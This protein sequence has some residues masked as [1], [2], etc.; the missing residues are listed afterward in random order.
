MRGNFFYHNDP[1]QTKD[2]QHPEHPNWS[3]L[4]D[5]GHVDEDGFLDLAVGHAPVAPGVL[6]ERQ[7]E[8]FGGHRGVFGGIDVHRGVVGPILDPTKAAR[9]D[10]ALVRPPRLGHALLHGHHK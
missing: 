6:P 1:G 5:V 3:A 8:A 2:A 10:R 7:Q 9:V 4:G